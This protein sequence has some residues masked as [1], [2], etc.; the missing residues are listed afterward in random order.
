M[1]E[2]SFVNQSIFIFKKGT[3]EMNNEPVMEMCDYAEFN[4]ALHLLNATSNKLL[5]NALS[6]AEWTF[7]MYKRIENYVCS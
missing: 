3:R 6:D 2:M 7:E 4:N 5:H 1:M